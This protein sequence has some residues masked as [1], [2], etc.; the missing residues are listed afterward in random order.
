[1]VLA[2][3]SVAGTKPWPAGKSVLARELL[4]ARASTFG[5][6]ESVDQTTGYMQELHRRELLSPKEERLLF[7]ALGDLKQCAADLREIPVDLRCGQTC[8]DLNE[9]EDEIIQFR[10]H[11]VESNLRLVVAAARKFRS[12]VDVDFH[13]LI[14]EGNAILMK[15]V[16]LFKIEFGYR[17][18]TYAMTALHRG[19]FS[20]V[21]R[22]H[23]RR[24]RFRCGESEH[25]EGV[26]DDSTPEEF[27]LEAIHDVPKLLEEL[28]VRERD[29]ITGRFG[30]AAGEKAKTFRELGDRY[31]LSK[32]RIRQVTNEA[33]AKMRKKTEGL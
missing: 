30:L 26:E 25:L 13:D 12:S 16:D 17:F 2:T 4:A 22:E 32:E 23:K 5:I 31:G 14:C 11:L 29:I 19:F 28:D 20:Y 24:N 10:N 6:S 15:A 8:R 27:A 3:R 33:L 9:V 7:E 18:S 1:M 21:Q